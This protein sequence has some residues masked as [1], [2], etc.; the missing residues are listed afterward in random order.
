MARLELFYPLKPLW[1]NQAFGIYNLA[2]KQFGFTEHNGWD[3]AISEGQIAY[4]MCD[5]EVTEVGFNESAG[6]YVKY[7]TRE[8]VWVEGKLERVCFMYMHGKKPLVIK[9]QLV[10][11]GDLIQVCNNTGFSTGNHLH[12]SGFMVDDEGYKIRQGR[13]ETDW[14]FDFSQYY[15][16]FFAVDAQKLFSLY[17]NLIALL[18][19]Q[20]KR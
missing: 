10:K 9:G 8:K 20:L 11:A 12:I 14:C 18:Q 1:V 5:G 15:N 17:H 6:N 13:K 16:R 2:Y 19:M 7:T 3:Y 4:A